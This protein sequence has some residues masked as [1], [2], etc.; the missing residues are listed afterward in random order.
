MSDSE[1]EYSS[2]EHTA[3]AESS[4]DGDSDHEG[5]YG[6]EPEYSAVELMLMG[7]ESP[8]ED[9]LESEGS[10]LDSSRLENMHWCSCT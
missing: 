7:D 10:D 8:N 2:E 9:H 5:M 1:S 6:N 3:D 4:Y